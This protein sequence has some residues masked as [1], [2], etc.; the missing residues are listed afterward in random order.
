MQF[1]LFFLVILGVIFGLKS[2]WFEEQ[3]IETD[4][5]DRVKSFFDVI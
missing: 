5:E 4:D 1:W 2:L 3:T